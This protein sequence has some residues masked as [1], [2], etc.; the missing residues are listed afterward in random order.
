M[1]FPPPGVHCLFLRLFCRLALF[2][3]VLLELRPA[4]VQELGD[5]VHDAADGKSVQENENHDH[6]KLFCELIKLCHIHLPRIFLNG[7]AA[8]VTAALC[9]LRKDNRRHPRWRNHPRHGSCRPAAPRRRSS[10]G[11]SA[12]RRCPGC[13]WS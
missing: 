2:L 13:H 7:R 9:C 10:A 3:P 1:L 12:R 11:C 4:P 6:I 5:P 8:A